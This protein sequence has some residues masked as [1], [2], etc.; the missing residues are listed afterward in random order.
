MGVDLRWCGALEQRVDI[1]CEV[2]GQIF[3]RL[4][5]TRRTC[6]PSFSKVNFWEI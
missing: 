1:V 5:S 6:S 3:G 4:H 2:G